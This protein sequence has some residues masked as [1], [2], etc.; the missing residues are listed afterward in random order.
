IT[1]ELRLKNEIIVCV[2]R[3]CPK[4][5]RVSMTES[6]ARNKTAFERLKQS[7]CVTGT[8]CYHETSFFALLCSR[9]TGHG[10]AMFKT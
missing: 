3:F 8:R 9:W 6:R 1:G 4:Q 7:T 5:L 2:V 10:R